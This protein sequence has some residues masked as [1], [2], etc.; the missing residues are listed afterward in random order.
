MQLLSQLTNEIKIMAMTRRWNQNCSGNLFNAAKSINRHMNKLKQN[1][2]GI[3]QLRVS[4][5]KAAKDALAV[6]THSKIIL[7]NW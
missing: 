5:V 3:K 1:V 7:V 6:D 4:S 2:V